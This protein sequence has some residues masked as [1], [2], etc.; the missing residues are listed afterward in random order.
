MKKY[1]FAGLIT[2]L[3]LVITLLIVIWV[4]NLLTKPFAGIMESIIF[5]YESHLHL[6]LENHTALVAF[7]SRF[8]ALIFLLILILVLGFFGQ[9]FFMRLV[10]KYTDRLF[11]KIPLIRTIYKM[12]LD[13]TKAMFTDNASLFKETV[14]I[15]F[16]SQKSLAVGLTTGEIPP[17]F[18]R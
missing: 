13:L 14:L 10:L 7:F 11:S 4:F 2:L 16:P 5:S 8:L 1:F 15:P 3:P 9:K 12:S 6:S 17:P 18:P